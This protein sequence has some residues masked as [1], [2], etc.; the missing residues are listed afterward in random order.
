M[1]ARARRHF[2]AEQDR[3]SR[4][5]RPGP[6][7]CTCERSAMMNLVADRFV[8]TANGRVVDLATGETVVLTISSAGGP[9]DQLRWAARCA[10]FHQLH[11]P[12][13]AQLV[14][15]GALG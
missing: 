13:L 6:R 10:W 4:A 3:R 11:H 1:T 5:V 15:Y 12:I 9:S 8:E 2:V 7:S 14:D